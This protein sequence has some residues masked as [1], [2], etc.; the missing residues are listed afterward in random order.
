MK[1]LTFFL[2]IILNNC[3]A[4]ETLLGIVPMKDGWINYSGSIKIDSASEDI[5]NKAKSWI[6]NN[7]NLF[8]DEKGNNKLG[9]DQFFR[10]NNL[11]VYP[12]YITYKMYIDILPNQINYQVKEFWAHFDFSNEN[13]PLSKELKENLE[14]WQGFSKNKKR[15]ILIKV[16]SHVKPFIKTFTVAM[17]APTPSK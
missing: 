10:D 4:Q 8:L 6:E 3:F 7:A 11:C 12:T 14:T 13:M 16:D 2:T 15:K 17:Q 1:K 9:G 5:Y